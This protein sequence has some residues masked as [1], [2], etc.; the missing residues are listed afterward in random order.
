MPAFWEVAP[1]SPQSDQSSRIRLP[2]V[3]DVKRISEVGGLAKA[4]LELQTSGKSD[5]AAAFD[6]P[7]TVFNSRLQAP[8]R[9]ATQCF[10]V[11]RMS[12]LAKNLGVSL[13]DVV[14]S[15]SAGALRSYLIEHSELPKKSLTAGIPVSIRADETVG[16]AISFI[17]AKLHTDIA[18]PIE[19]LRAINRSTTLAKER[20][21]NLSSRMTQEEVFGSL[22]M[23]PHFGLV[24]LNLGGR[25]V[26]PVFNLIISN[27]PGSKEFL[28]LEGARMEVFYPI[29]AITDGL[30]L[31]ITF[32]SYAGRYA[33][34][35]TACREAVPHMQ[36]VAVAAGKHSTNWKRPP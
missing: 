13:N 28:Y 4:L 3:S 14:L 18:D 2:K 25:G 11:D 5:N 35:F 36:H 17:I 24:A 31:N 32:L 30:A 29:S 12:R 8:R 10:Q 20:F 26:P 1:K 21:K 23:A 7:K 9:V 15:V 19:R 34:G 33:A 6:A 22:V 16:N 27:I